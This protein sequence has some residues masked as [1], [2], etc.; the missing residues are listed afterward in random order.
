LTRLNVRE[1]R[2]AK[3]LPAL[4]KKGFEKRSCWRIY[5]PGNL[6]RVAGN[7]VFASAASLLQR[8]GYD[9]VGANRTIKAITRNGEKTKNTSSA[10]FSSIAWDVNVALLSLI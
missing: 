8:F 7:Y 2:R 4:K 9:G 1:L 3:T 5:L 10:P 6:S